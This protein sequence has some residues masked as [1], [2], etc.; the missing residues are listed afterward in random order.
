MR[1]EGMDE[2]MVRLERMG[3]QGDQLRDR[4]VDKAAE[5]LQQEIAK[6]VYSTGLNRRTGIAGRSIVR[7]DVKDGTVDIG[8][9]DSGFYLRFWEFGFY[10]KRAGRRMGPIP[11]VAPVFERNRVLLRTIMATEVRRGLQGIRI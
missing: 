3:R 8:P 11:V 9:D 10:N 7:S 1:F 2:L 6:N 4:A 5:R